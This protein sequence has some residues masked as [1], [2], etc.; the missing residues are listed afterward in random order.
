VDLFELGDVKGL[1]RNYVSAVLGG[2][3]VQLVLSSSD[4]D[5]MLAI[6]Y[7]LFGQSP[8]NAG[9]GTE[10]EDFVLLERHA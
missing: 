9:G 7:D 10:N 6:S 4:D 3:F 2:E 5:N 1:G 8:P